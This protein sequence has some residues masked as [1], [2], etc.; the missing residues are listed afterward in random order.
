MNG[1]D[2]NYKGTEEEEPKPFKVKQDALKELND[3]LVNVEK[4]E[5]GDYSNVISHVL[6]V[7]SVFRNF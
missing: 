3:K 5:N 4:L 2:P 7:F 1:V 6:K